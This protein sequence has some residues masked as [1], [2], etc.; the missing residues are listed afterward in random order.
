MNTFSPVIRTCVTSWVFEGYELV[1]GNSKFT[2]SL[3]DSA[4]C[5]VGSRVVIGLSAMAIAHACVTTSPFLFVAASIIKIWA[6][7]D[8]LY[9][10][11]LAIKTYRL[12][13]SGLF[14]AAT[15][16]NPRALSGACF[17]SDTSLW[18]DLSKFGLIC[19]LLFQ[20]PIPTIPRF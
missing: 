3:F 11:G 19:T 4:I 7:I 17:P 8:A 12:Y 20:R 2:V 15:E 6:V 14:A 5:C 18:H 9:M 10:T 13:G 1:T 16:S